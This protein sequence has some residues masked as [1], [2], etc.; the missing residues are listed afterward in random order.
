MLEVR[1]RAHGFS[2]LLLQPVV[3]LAL[4]WVR[5]TPNCSKMALAAAI[6]QALS[7]V[8]VFISLDEILHPIR[9]GRSLLCPLS[10]LLRHL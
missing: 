9:W 7:Q 6:L 3:L 4:I 1:A 2:G 8:L 5:S 10:E